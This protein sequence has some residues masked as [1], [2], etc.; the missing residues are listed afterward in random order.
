MNII[1][2]GSTELTRASPPYV[3]AEIGVNHEGSMETAKKL[4]EL[5]KEGGAN[6]AKFQ[7]YKANKLASKHSPAYWDINKEKT[8]SQFELFSKLDSFGNQEYA[9]LSE[10]CKI[11]EIDFVSTPFDNQAVEMLNPICPYFKIASADILNVP[12]LRKIALTKKTILLSTGA[13]NNIEIDFAINELYLSGATDI[14]LLH[15][16]LNYP[17]LDNNANLGMIKGLRDTY[18]NLIVGYSDH[19]LPTPNMDILIN[20]HLMGAVVIEKHFTHDK[21]LKGNDHYHAMDIKDLKAFWKSFERIQNLTGE[22][23]EKVALAGEDI[24]ILHARR[25][26]VSNKKIHMGELLT[27]EN[28]TTKRPGHGISSK[29]W[30]KIIGKTAKVDIEDDTILS[31]D[32]FI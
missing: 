13:A 23:Y 19:T 21:T 1:K 24:A 27:N 15:C 30:D 10:F 17:T 6:C 4:I 32:M 8:K 5:A 16:V 11:N 20:A 22:Q 18:P 9:E 28:L 14:V 12:L 2:L 3:I 25:S 31:F 7:T 26:I 29:E